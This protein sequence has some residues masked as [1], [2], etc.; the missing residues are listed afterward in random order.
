MLSQRRIVDGAAKDGHDLLA[1]Q[2]R[3]HDHFRS[4]EECRVHLERRILGGCTDENDVSGFNEW[5][6]R[7]L[8]R[9]VEAVDL[10]DENDRIRPARSPFATSFLH[11]SANL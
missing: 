2:S 5:E 11:Q 7:V 10:V 6:K 1:L 3:E 4:R 8:L 9:F